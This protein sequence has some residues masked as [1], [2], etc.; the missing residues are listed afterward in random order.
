MVVGVITGHT[1]AVNAYRHRICLR[2]DPLCDRFTM[3]EETAEHLTC[4]CPA[5]EAARK[6]VFGKSPIQPLEVLERDPAG[7][8]SLLRRTGR[9]AVA[10][11]RGAT[12]SGNPQQTATALP[13]S[14]T[15]TAGGAQQ[16]RRNSTWGRV[17]TD[18]PQKFPL[19]RYCNRSVLRN[20]LSI[21]GWPPTSPIPVPIWFS[22]VRNLFYFSRFHFYLFICLK[23]ESSKFNVKFT[24]WIGEFKNHQN[25]GL[26]PNL[27]F[28]EYT[29]TLKWL[30]CILS[31]LNS[32]FHQIHNH[33]CELNCPQFI[34]SLEAPWQCWL[35]Y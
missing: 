16:R 23:S 26:V 25:W 31:C 33:L 20:R 29:F 8:C 24:N 11:T 3:E 27:K 35:Q 13:Y 30:K 22:D 19:G 17:S 7:I 28:W 15:A 2:D 4:W 9:M 12:R 6:G 1:T 10:S 18:L 21:L 32:I 14:A 34:P 5:W